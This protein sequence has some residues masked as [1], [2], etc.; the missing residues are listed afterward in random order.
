MIKWIE[1]RLRGS[2]GVS[3]RKKSIVDQ[4]SIVTKVTQKWNLCNEHEYLWWKEH[5]MSGIGYL[6]WPWMK[7]NELKWLWTE[8]NDDLIKWIENGL[9]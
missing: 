9:D 5:D 2:R 8:L 3:W 6:N 7:W 1:T 4:I